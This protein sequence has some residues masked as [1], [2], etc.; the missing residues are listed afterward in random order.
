MKERHVQA[1]DMDRFLSIVAEYRSVDVLLPSAALRAAVSL[2]S[3]V[4]FIS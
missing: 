3:P 2:H 4:S 1:A